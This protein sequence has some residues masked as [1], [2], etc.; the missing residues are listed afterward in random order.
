VIG[1]PRQRNFRK[2]SSTNCQGFT[3]KFALSLQRD[4]NKGFFEK[5]TLKIVDNI[6][7]R[8]ND[9]SVTILNRINFG[10]KISL[11]AKMEQL[12]VVTTDDYWNPKFIDRQS[13]NSEIVLFKLIALR[14]LLNLG[15]LG[16]Q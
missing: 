3:S 4:Q 9:V 15:Q 14:K 5:L 12:Q 8:I 1:A 6:Q 7:L 13:N 16:R 2:K 11:Q 10:K